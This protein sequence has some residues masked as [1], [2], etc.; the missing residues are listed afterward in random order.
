[1]TLCIGEIV[2]TSYNTGPYRIVRATGPHTSPSYLDSINGIDR[3]SEPH[4][5]LVCVWAGPVFERGA[6]KSK[7]EYYLNG[8]RLDGT[9]VWGDDFDFRERDGRRQFETVCFIRFS[10]T[11]NLGETQN[12][13]ADVARAA[14]W[15]PP[16]ATWRSPTLRS[17]MLMGSP[18][19]TLYMKIAGESTRVRLAEVD[20]RG[21]T[22]LRAALRTSLRELVGKRAVTATWDKVDRYGRPIVRVVVDGVVS[23][24]SR[25][26]A[27]SLGFIV[28]IR[29]IR[30]F[31]FLRM[32]R[33]LRGAGCG[34]MRHRSSLGNGE[35][36]QMSQERVV[37]RVQT[38]AAPLAGVFEEVFQRVAS[39]PTTR[40]ARVLAGFAASLANGDEPTWADRATTRR[41]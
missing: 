28:G 33:G 32:K 24:P 14:F 15:W 35:G 38:G 22:A 12:E 1:M 19:A 30:A 37:Y 4:F 36:A 2:R 5:C 23:M 11:R 20:A 8:Y 16:L 27:V 10:R 25:C 6:R 3:P 18:M 9:S 41:G 34:R 40:A 7:E 17:A 39:S 13:N 21:K 31:M 29:R 26:G